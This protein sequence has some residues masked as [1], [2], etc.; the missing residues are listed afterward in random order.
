MTIDAKLTVLYA[1]YGEWQKDLPQMNSVCASVLE[2]DG[3]VFNVAI[4]KLQAEGYIT[5]AEFLYADQI[6]QPV[7]VLLDRVT[8]T[9][10]GT[11]KVEADL[12]LTQRT[13]KERAQ[14]L[15]DKAAQFGWQVLSQIIAAKI[16]QM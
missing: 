2:M 12:K 16:A 11:D 15:A 6:P 5:G 10:K 9:Q 7:S 4:F 13:G 3:I 14:S 8:L 1:L